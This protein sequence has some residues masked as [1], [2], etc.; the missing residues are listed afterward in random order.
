M[1]IR[2]RMNLIFG[3]DDFADKLDCNVLESKQLF[4]SESE[5]NTD[6]FE[7]YYLC[8]SFV[9]KDGNWG[10]AADYIYYNWH[11]DNS[12]LGFVVNCTRY[13]SNFMRVLSIFHPEYELNGK[14]DIPIWDKKNHLSYARCVEKCMRPCG[15]IKFQWSWFYP[16]IIEQHQ[17]WPVYAYCARWLFQQ[18]G[19]N[20]DYHKYKAM[21]VW[22][23]V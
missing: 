15:D 7:N 20:I 10:C 11:S 6:N 21:L 8:D 14:L 1:G 12:I 13:D 18:I 3:I 9:D 23:W 4:I 19:L 2:P 16:S 22:E 5:I 17:M